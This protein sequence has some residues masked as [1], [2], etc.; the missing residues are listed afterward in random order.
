MNFGATYILAPSKPNFWQSSVTLTKGN[1]VTVQRD[2]PYGSRSN[3]V[4]ANFS[5]NNSDKYQSTMQFSVA[6]IRTTYSGSFPLDEGGLERRKDFLLSV[7]AGPTFKW[8]KTWQ[9]ALNVGMTSTQSN[10]AIYRFSRKVIG[11]S[12]RRMF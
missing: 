12:L 5:R 7:N 2:S 10:I 3:G 11:L 8:K 4:I 1:A 9:G 6:A